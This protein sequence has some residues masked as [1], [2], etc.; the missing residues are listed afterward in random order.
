MPVILR[1]GR[2]GVR[3]I[4]IVSRGYRHVVGYRVPA[5]NKSAR[6]YTSTSYCTLKHSGIFNRIALALII[7]CLRSLQFRSTFNGVLQIH[8]QAV[9]QTVRDCLAQCVAPVERQLLHPGNV[10]DRVFCRHR[11]ICDNVGAILLSVLLHYP[12][13]HLATAVVIEVCVYIRQRDTV[14]V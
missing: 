6:M 9:R 4:R 11:G 2:L 12:L 3:K 5:D 10:L 8:F 7:G 13:Q 1:H 14:R